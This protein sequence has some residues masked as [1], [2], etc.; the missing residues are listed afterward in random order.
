M[1]R[2]LKKLSPFWEHNPKE[3]AW[4]PRNNYYEHY[5][6]WASL[7]KPRSYLEIGVMYG[8]SAMAI[9]AGW[10]H[11]ERMVVIDSELY[12]IPVGDAVAE[13]LSFRFANEI[14][15]DFRIDGLKHDTTKLSRLPVGR[16][17]FDLIHIDGEHSTEAVKNDLKLA[18]E[19]LAD[20]GT[21][22]VDDICFD[23]VKA[24]A[25]FFLHNHP[26]VTCRRVETHQ[27]HYLIWRK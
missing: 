12:E 18:L 1:K 17:K 23:G 22:I 10:P 26:E 6:F 8:W 24:G 4:P 9:L 2:V 11:V 5:A 20:R 7:I 25:D 27:V 19:V 15:S 16:E 3:I 14:T 21:I 13:I